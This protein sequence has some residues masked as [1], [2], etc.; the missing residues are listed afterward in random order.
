[1]IIFK[2]R[3][4]QQLYNF[5]NIMK[6]YSD[7]EEACKTWGGTLASITSEEDS[8]KVNNYLDAKGEKHRYWIGLSDRA[9]EGEFVWADGREKFDQATSW[10]NWDVDKP[11][12][13]PIFDLLHED[14]VN[15]ADTAER[16]WHDSRCDYAFR[17]ICKKQTEVNDIAVR[18]IQPLVELPKEPA[19]VVDDEPDL[20][21]E[22]REA[23]ARMERAK[24]KANEDARV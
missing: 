8:D 17:Y 11:R 18:M 1:M 23:E 6:T 15:L 4:I 13:D 16:K 5:S 14:C 2:T 19:P 12:T 24:E 10:S 20:D 3:V 22:K 21:E 7:A 9:K